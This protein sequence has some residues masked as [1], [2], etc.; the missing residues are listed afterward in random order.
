MSTE[1]VD[2]VVIGSG[3]GGAV[4]AARLA[5]A[6]LKVV[7]L[8]RGQRMAPESFRQSDDVRYLQSVVEFV[9]SSNNVLMR[10]GKLVGGAS[11]AMDGAHFR[12]P[13]Q[14]FERTDASGYRY[15]PAAFT[16]ESLDPYYDVA[17]ATLG[18]RQFAWD[19][20]PK[21][22]GLFA[23]MVAKAGGTCD[24]ARMNYTDCLQCGFCSQGCIYRKKNSMV[25]TYLPLAEAEG[26]QIRPNCEVMTIEPDGSGWV[27][28]YREGGE[29][30][31]IRG[32]KLF[33]ACGGIQTPALLLR[34][35]ALKA[36]SLAH[37]GEHF[38]INGEIAY[39]ALLPEDFDDLPA[40]HCYR[41]ADNAAV[42][43]YHWYE[44]EGFTLHPGGGLEPL[45][46]AAALA[47]PGHPVLPPR[48]WGM[49][50]KRFI[51]K[52]Y[53]SRLVAFAA[54]GLADGFG[55][56]GLRADGTANILPRDRTSWD[57]YHDR[58]DNV[59]QGVAAAT[60]VTIRPGYSRDLSG[61][62]SAHLLAS[63]RMSDAP[64]DG[65]VD[66]SCQVWGYEN[67]Y[68]TDASAIPYALGVNPSL[69]IT[70]VAERAVEL[71]IA[72]G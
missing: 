31:C 47:E 38:N 58:V 62:T 10:T 37:V 66:S 59:L 16:R 46:L 12:T 22:G 53:P 39:I 45:V 6:G 64:E 27:A 4:P 55:A 29:T 25:E 2:A 13:T 67:L 40:Y 15:W 9:V 50:Y 60:G 28:N 20:I 41:G 23:K 44:S 48:S 7:V 72:K 52:V 49:D 26:A 54:L 51:E 14:S 35:N 71:A 33:V 69:T 17:E 36:L 56:I 30:K 68:I 21:G 63:C 5:Q 3:Y 42:M 8:E 32:A 11:I 70:A 57:A 18:V 1:S 65:V 34:S 61:T 19:E 24:R 43:C